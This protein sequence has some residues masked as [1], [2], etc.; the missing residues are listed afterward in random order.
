M[1]TI[2]TAF[3]ILLMSLN[4]I[5]QENLFH[6]NEFWKTQPDLTKVKELI[7]DGNDPVALN[8]NGFDA[9]VY[10]IIRNANDDVIEYLLLLNGNDPNK[11]THDS[12]NYLHWAA[13]AGKVDIVNILL[14]TGSS[15]TQPDSHGYTPLAFAADAGVKDLAIYK[16]FKN[17]GV[18]LETEK[19]K[20][21]ASLLLLI[22][23]SLQNEAELDNFLDLGLSLNSR[24]NDGNNIFH[25]AARKGNISFLKMLIEK[26]VDAKAINK[27]GGNAIL[28]ASRGARGYQNSLELY[29][30]LESQGIA[31]N[32]VGDYGRNPL[33]AIAYR[34][35]DIAILDYFINKGVNINLQDEGG[36]SP[37]MNGAT[38]NTVEIVSFL[39][40]RGVDLDA[41]DETGK[42]ALAMAI[43]RNDADVVA[44]L[45]KNKADTGIL[46]KKGNSL[47]YYLINSYSDR[48]TDQ[49]GEKLKL[50]KAENISMA[51]TQE[52]NNT[53]YH[54]A[55]SI[56]NLNLIKHLVDF[57]ININAKNEEGLTA[58]HL[59]AM[60]AEDDSIIKYLISKGAD[61][62]LK[63]DFEES[64]FD[65]ASE[66]ELLK[67]NNTSL[68][69]L[70]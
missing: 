20:G 39:F 12:R 48:N 18:D 23:S 61:S 43:N 31:V 14:K 13:Y 70:K 52:D 10:A 5:G 64:V 27:N 19:S 11:K 33:H 4:V 32:V 60:K 42:T 26:G 51:T 7:E 15:V 62:K 49:F 63:T 17:H 1:K 41:Q 58:L 50:L 67:N 37:F 29:K 22:A 24:D 30:F 28:M 8:Q 55:V 57:N 53:L 66:N 16:A 40:D 2:L 47:A 56:G 9:T 3:F 45:L 38:S 34:T 68:N 65:L 6:S 46:D 44:F 69:F 21:G 54:I 59:A 25:Y 36:A 35:D